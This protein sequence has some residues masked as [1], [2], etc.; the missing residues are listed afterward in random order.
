VAVYDR[1]EASVAAADATRH[2]LLESL[3]AEASA[4][5]EEREMEAAE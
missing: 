1:L 2:R 4:P 5:R 3:I